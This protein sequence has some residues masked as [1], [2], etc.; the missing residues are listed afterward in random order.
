[1]AAKVPRQ[2]KT[3]LPSRPLKYA[4]FL[5]SNFITILGHFLYYHSHEKCST[6]GNT[7]HIA[8][9]FG[10]LLEEVVNKQY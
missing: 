10:T 1:M 5:H 7:Q 2:D 8:K 3:S 9:F 4:Y 6:E